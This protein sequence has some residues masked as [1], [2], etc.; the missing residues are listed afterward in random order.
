MDKLRERLTGSQVVFSQA[1]AK[2]SQQRQI[3]SR[4]RATFTECEAKH[5][6]STPALARLVAE[7]DTLTDRKTTLSKQL[8][9]AQTILTTQKVKLN[10]LQVQVLLTTHSTELACA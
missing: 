8:D 4:L 6:H 10:R 3:V 7:R 9:N 5:P 2:L 1:E